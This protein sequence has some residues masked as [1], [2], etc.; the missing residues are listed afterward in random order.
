ME[1][2]LNKEADQ[3]IG[4]LIG[5]ARTCNM[6]L[7]TENTDTI[8][9]KSLSAIFQ[10]QEINSLKND[11]SE[12]N[13]KNG[14]NQKNDSQKNDSCTGISKQVTEEELSVLLQRVRE[15][16]LAVAP[17][18]ATCPVRCGNTDEFDINL[19]RN[20]KQEICHLKMQL[21]SNACKMSAHIMAYLT[22]MTASLSKKQEEE[23]AQIYKLL[24]VISYD[25]TEEYLKSFL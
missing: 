25:V 3:L 17:D 10:L 1:I 16:Q 18:C 23:I 15:E 21:L 14:Y 12:D 9:L 4:A 20:E 2:Y 13:T 19:I 6:H 11:N 8:V 5:L 22:E 7:K 24:C